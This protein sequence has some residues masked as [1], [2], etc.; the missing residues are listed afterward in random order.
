MVRI[1][2]G[3]RIHI[4]INLVSPALC[5]IKA[6]DL[7]GRLRFVVCEDTFQGSRN[8]FWDAGNLG[9]GV[10]M[11]YAESGSQRARGKVVVVR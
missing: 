9:S 5:S 4:Q 11:I 10:Y 8:I 1:S 7:S 6:Y 3:E 2:Q